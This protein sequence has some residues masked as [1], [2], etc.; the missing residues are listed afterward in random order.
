MKTLILL[1]GLTLTG[2]ANIP[3]ARTYSV[4]LSDGK[5]TAQASIRLEPPT[6]GLR[7]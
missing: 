2:C 3:V 1:I 7:K 4:F 6:K 5:A